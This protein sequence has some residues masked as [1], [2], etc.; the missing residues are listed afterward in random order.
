MSYTKMTYNT[1]GIHEE[2]YDMKTARILRN[3]LTEIDRNMMRRCDLEEY[4]V[5]L[6]RWKLLVVS[7]AKN[8]RREYYAQKTQ[9]KRNH[10]LQTFLD[11]RTTYS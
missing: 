7:M 8:Q 1:Q 10:W 3:Y 11:F 9:G 6:Y 5:L 2:Y 4:E